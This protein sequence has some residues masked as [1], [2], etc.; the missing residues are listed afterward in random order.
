MIKMMIKSDMYGN[1]IHESNDLYDIILSDKDLSLAKVE[2]SEK[3]SMFNDMCK[4]FDHPEDVINIYTKPKESIEEF[5]KKNQDNWYIPDEYK[6]IN[7]KNF[8]LNKVNTTEE[9]E[10]ILLEYTMF[11]ERGMLDVLKLFIYI[12]DV[13]KENKIVWGIGRGSSVSSYILYIIGVHKV[14]SIKYE[15]DPRDFLK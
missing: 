14:N 8:L 7:V 13:L 15:L 6:N 12:V 9:K 1:V 11:T 3:I 4:I 2:Y 5:D 10:R